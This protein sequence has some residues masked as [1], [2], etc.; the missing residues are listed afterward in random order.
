M[1][2]QKEEERQNVREITLPVAG[3]TCAACVRKVEK[4]LK[5]L[6]GVAD[7]TVNL[8]AG[9]AGVVF[10]PG[11]C[12]VIEM[13]KVI[14]D[15]GYEVPASRLDLLVLGMTPGHCDIVIGDALRALPGVRTVTVNPATDT[16]SV[17]FL[18]SAVSAATIKRTVRS[19]GYDVHEKGEGA[20]ALDRERQ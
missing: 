12:S 6:P 13:E 14:E 9:K 18:E 16:V 10:D 4:A 5:G 7:A 15:I 2:K 17:E 1:V 19:L 8:S 11:A 20:D 3:M